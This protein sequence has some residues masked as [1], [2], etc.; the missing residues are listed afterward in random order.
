MNTEKEAYYG[1]GRSERRK[2]VRR[3][4]EETDGKISL[5]DWAKDQNPVGDA[6]YAWLR[7]K[8]LKQRYP[9]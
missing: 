6:A 5:K 7:S 4:R 1:I 2:M 3:W 9:S 8:Q